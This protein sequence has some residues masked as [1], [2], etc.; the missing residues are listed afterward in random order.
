MRHPVR[1][2][3]VIAATVLALGACGGADKTDPAG[4]SAKPK[5]YGDCQVTGTRGS[6][7]LE[8]A[9]KN[10]LLI[11][12]D[13]PSPGWYN[14]DTVEQIR[15]GFDFCLAA[16]IAHRAGLDNV[17]LVNASFDALVAGKAGDFD[18]SLN[19]I[20]IT[21]E[22]R[23]VMDFSDPYFDSTAGILVK[24]GANVTEANLRT[25]SF[26][27]KQG[28]V[29]Q[30]L[31]T[32]AIKPAEI[33]PFPGDPELQAAVAAGRVDVGIQ[34]LSIVLGAA[35]KS[36]G[37]LAVVG[38]L[39]TDESYGVMMTKGSPNLTT[40]N[41]ILKE[42]KDDGTMD[43]LSAA[44]LTDAYGIDPATVPIWKIG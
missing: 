19:Q 43:A 2:T 4:T 14:G 40:I 11:K 29:G 41:T 8:T 39:S 37:K 21:D 25:V 38:Q 13:L 23:K 31:A 15:S 6:H 35:A 27:V 42:L 10:T 33:K 1:L 22:R 9:T 3:A 44:Y 17:R 36:G 16:N 24:K 30:I 7:P 26:G 28:T 34:D 12:A 32:E 18:L 5:S 20:T